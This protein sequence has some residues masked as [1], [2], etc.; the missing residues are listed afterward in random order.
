MKTT[1][2]GASAVCDIVKKLVDD[3]LE[4]AAQKAIQR[5]YW[6]PCFPSYLME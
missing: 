6:I 3:G 5:E 1:E 4:K 2:G